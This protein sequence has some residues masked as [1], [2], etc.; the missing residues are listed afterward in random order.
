MEKFE[1][2]TI[3]AC[4]A[5]ADCDNGDES[6]RQDAL[7]VKS[8]LGSGERFD[9]VVFGWPMPKTHDDWNEMKEDSCAWEPLA[10]D[11][12]VRLEEES[13]RER[14]RTMT[15]FECYEDNG[16]MLHLFILDNNGKA[17]A[18]FGNFECSDDADLA[19]AI[20]NIDNYRLF[21]GDY[22]GD[23]EMPM[24]RIIGDDGQDIFDRELTINE[25]YREYVDDETSTLIA[26][27]DGNTVNYCDVSKM[28]FA[29][30]K[31]LGLG[32]NE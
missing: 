23:I 4:T 11:H 5:I 10:F 9:R 17:V 32:L 12:K 22:G 14:N 3:C 28:G 6:C 26:W 13:D 1:D 30:R 20:A 16:G 19:D 8:V 25:L 2:C 15:K 7:L 18:G 29:A 24:H 27:S 21:G 31:A